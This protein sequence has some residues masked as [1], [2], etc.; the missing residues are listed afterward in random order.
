MRAGLI[1]YVATTIVFFGMDFVWLST[2]MGILYRPRLGPLLLDRPRLGVAG[3]FYLLYVLGIVLFAVLP[4]AAGGDWTRA[5]GSGALF[6]L[7][8]YG[9]YDMTNLATLKGWSWTVTLVDMA[10]GTVATGTA[11]LAGYA[12]LQWLG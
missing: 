11:A 2:A 6:G 1:A 5:L 4:A 7:V 12:A 3:G 8:A 10:W 9:T